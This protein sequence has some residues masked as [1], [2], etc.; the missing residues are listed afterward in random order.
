VLMKDLDGATRD[1]LVAV[2]ADHM[3]V[4]YQRY[5]YCFFLSL[6]EFIICIVVLRIKGAT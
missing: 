4:T 6:Y 2:L 5:K 3:I 1:L